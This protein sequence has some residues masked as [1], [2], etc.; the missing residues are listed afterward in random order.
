MAS[1]TPD[2]K[3]SRIL[4][5]FFGGPTAMILI[6]FILFPYPLPPYH[7]VNLIPL[8]AG[9]ILLGI[10]TLDKQQQRG[11]RFKMTGW[12]LFALFWTTYTNLLYFSEGG[13]IVNAA[14]CVIG[15]Y[16]LI[17]LA[18]HEWLST[19]RREYPPPST[20]SPAPPALPA[21]STSP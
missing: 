9:L 10:G 17:Y 11:S 14:I 5:W 13:D 2:T 21:S 7:W 4:L 19:K 6:N 18:Y 20:G 3:D 12:I 15:I 8:F 1:T 16:V